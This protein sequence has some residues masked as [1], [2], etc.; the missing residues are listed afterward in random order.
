MHPQTCKKLGGSIVI[1]G[2]VAT[3][4]LALAGMAHTATRLAQ[5]DA[6]EKPA[7][8]GANLLAAKKSAIVV[9]EP[10]VQGYGYDGRIN[11]DALVAPGAHTFHGANATAH[12][13]HRHIATGTNAPTVDHDAFSD[14][15]KYAR[16]TVK[17]ITGGAAAFSDNFP[18]GAGWQPAVAAAPS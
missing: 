4:A 14:A 16:A 18:S 17:A 3:A 1:T 15:A 12:G 7:P 10:Q 6:E 5:S 9:G 11:V 13:H 2:S 8:P